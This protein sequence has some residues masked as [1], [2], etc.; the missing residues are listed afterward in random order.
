MNA[1]DNYDLLCRGTRRQE[2]SHPV[3]SFAQL[4]NQSCR[5]VLE[6]AVEL[7]WL[8]AKRV[9]S[10]TCTCSSK[11]S[12]CQPL[13]CRLQHWAPQP[14]IRYSSTDLL[15]LYETNASSLLL[16][17]AGRAGAATADHMAQRICGRQG[18]RPIASEPGQ[19]WLFRLDGSARLEMDEEELQ[20]SAS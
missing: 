12:H 18:T 15:D 3:C 11:R 13:L 20:T 7:L 5:P 16:M 10:P 2:C 4:M 14:V 1:F 19:S 9:P 8:S 6:R 17:R